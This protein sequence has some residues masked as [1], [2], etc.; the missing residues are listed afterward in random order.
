[1]SHK[2][3]ILWRLYQVL[4]NLFMHLAMISPSW[5]TANRITWARTILGIPIIL[6][7]SQGMIWEAFV[8]YVIAWLMDFLDGV[9][10]KAEREKGINRDEVYG[11]FLDAFC[12]KVQLLLMVP[13][14]WVLCDFEGPLYFQ[15]TLVTLTLMLMVIEIALGVVRLQDYLTKKKNPNA[16]R[17]IKSTGWGKVKLILEVIGL[18]GLLLCYPNLVHWAGYVGL[19]SLVLAV[20][21][22]IKSLKQKLFTRRQ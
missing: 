5:I 14:I 19:A 22:G 13:F 8:I 10:A 17:A 7:L 2:P 6:A 9:W 1:M 3:S 12:D 18:G 21:F 4:Q 16:K 20:P 15:A 11:A